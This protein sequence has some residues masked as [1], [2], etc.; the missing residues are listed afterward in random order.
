MFYASEKYVAFYIT[1]ATCLINRAMKNVTF[2]C[3]HLYNTS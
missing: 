3:K 2:A 1:F